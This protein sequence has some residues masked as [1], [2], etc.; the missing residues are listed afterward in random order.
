MSK[1]LVAAVAAAIVLSSSSAFG[2]LP[3][4]KP[5]DMK[6]AGDACLTEVGSKAG[7]C[8]DAGGS[9]T[10]NENTS[11]TSSAS[12]SGAASS[13]GPPAD[14]SKSS[15]CSVSRLGTDRGAS[16]ALAA[17]GLAA[18]AALRRRRSPTRRRS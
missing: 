2:D 7:T 4:P 13:G 10:C 14:S 16:L 8:T 6:K 5:C 15:G 11:T 1:S 12:S 18:I 3:N 17:M 9:L